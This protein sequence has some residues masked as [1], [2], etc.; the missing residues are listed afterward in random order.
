MNNPI[1]RPVITV[2]NDDALCLITLISLSQE[3]LGNTKFITKP[4][5]LINKPLDKIITIISILVFKVRF[6]EK[7]NI[8]RE[9]N[10]AIKIII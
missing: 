8:T 1:R 2:I 7:L 6:K 3:K 4:Y 9:I 10:D 5:K